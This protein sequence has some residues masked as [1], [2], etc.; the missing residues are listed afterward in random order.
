PHRRLP[1]AAAPR[2]R[3]RRRRPGAA[4]P[5]LAGAASSA[6]AGDRRVNNRPG[7]RDAPLRGTR[8]ENALTGVFA[9]YS[10][11][12]CAAG[13]ETVP[14]R[15]HPSR[16]PTDFGGARA[17]R[18]RYV[19]RVR[20]ALGITFAALLLAIVVPGLASALALVVTP[21]ENIQVAGQS[22]D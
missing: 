18:C 5:H 6:A 21:S 20:R 19:G 13:S 11:R 12:H 9:L 1:P 15:V 7:G 16:P 2:A 3:R 4:T 8:V 14:L 10:R 22:I 17:R